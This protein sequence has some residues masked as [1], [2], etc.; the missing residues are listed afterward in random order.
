MTI[1]TQS[2]LPK[3][4]CNKEKY[5]H[6]EPG[7]IVLNSLLATFSYHGPHIHMCC[8]LYEELGDVTNMADISVRKSKRLS[9]LGIN[10]SNCD[11]QT[12]LI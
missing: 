9:S 8:L 3:I 2:H 6:L 4:G 7:E 10:F 12:S 5:R 1:T 11:L